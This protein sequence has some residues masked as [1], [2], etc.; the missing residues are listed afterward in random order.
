[1]FLRS[2]KEI[3]RL[4]IKGMSNICVKLGSHL[5]ENLILFASNESPLKIMKNVP[6]FMLKDMRYLYFCPDF[7]DM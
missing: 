4:I 1:M 5:P 2:V 3:S 6:Y 7:L